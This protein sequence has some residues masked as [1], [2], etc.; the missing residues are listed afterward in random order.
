MEIKKNCNNCEV[1]T[2][3]YSGPI[4]D[5]CWRCSNW[6]P[7]ATMQALI[8]RELGKETQKLTEYELYV[9]EDIAMAKT[10]YN[11]YFRNNDTIVD[12]LKFF[13]SKGTNVDIRDNIKDVIF[14]DPATIILWKDG[15]KTIVKAQ[16]G[17]L[18]DPEKGFAMAIAKKVLGG[19][20]NYFEVFK[21]WV[22]EEENAIKPIDIR[23]DCERF[24]KTIREGLKDGIKAMED[25]KRR[26]GVVDTDNEKEVL[27][28][29]YGSKAFKKLEEYEEDETE[30]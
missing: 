16:E 27:N 12:T 4:C 20:G 30:E 23:F 24:A 7:N 15:S 22:P 21:K 1:H 29:I 25:L 18:Y 11:N 5:T 19:Q 17:E 14:N 26:I 6:R 3:N 13:F 2:L 10:D 8:N 9:K 28:S